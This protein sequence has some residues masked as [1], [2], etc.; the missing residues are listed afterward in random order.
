[1]DPNFITYVWHNK[2]PERFG[3]KG[4]PRK[5]RGEIYIMSQKKQSKI[6]SRPAEHCAES[7][8]L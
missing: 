3:V 4:R 2:A 8:H 5:H 7:E 6:C 1:M